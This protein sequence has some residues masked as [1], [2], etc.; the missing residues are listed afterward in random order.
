M[1]DPAF[2][3]T[4]FL[5]ELGTQMGYSVLGSICV[6]HVCLVRV[7][8]LLRCRN[9][10]SSA[11]IPSCSCLPHPWRQTVLAHSP[12]GTEN[13]ILLVQ[14]VRRD[15][16]LNWTWVKKADLKGQRRESGLLFGEV[17]TERGTFC[18]CDKEHVTLG[19]SHLN[20]VLAVSLASCPIMHPPTLH[21][22]CGHVW[23]RFS[24]CYWGMLPLASGRGCAPG[25]L[26]H[27]LHCTGTAP[28][29]KT[30]MA[31]APIVPVVRKCCPVEWTAIF[32]LQMYR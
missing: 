28:T 32:C 23:R 21:G 27:A 29:T 3:L 4:W 22:T 6:Q 15:L 17:P 12:G 10:H 2:V 26:L 16:Q 11:W 19:P 7:Q 8:T 9:S 25:M 14:Y 1:V 31:H 5:T 13:K 30:H 18:G 20:T 24:C